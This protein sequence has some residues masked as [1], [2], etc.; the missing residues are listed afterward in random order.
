MAPKSFLPSHPALLKY[1]ALDC[2]YVSFVYDA[3][4]LLDLLPEASM[5]WKERL[6]RVVGLQ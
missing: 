3:K 4:A 5:I 6:R 2:C 1:V